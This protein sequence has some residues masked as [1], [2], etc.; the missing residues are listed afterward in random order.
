M[1][2]ASPFMYCGKGLPGAKGTSSKATE[3]LPSRSILPVCCRNFSRSRDKRLNCSLCTRHFS[4]SSRTLDCTAEAGQ[5]SK[6]GIQWRRYAPGHMWLL[7]AHAVCLCM[8]GAAS[9]S[10]EQQC[11]VAQPH[12]QPGCWPPWRTTGAKKSCHRSAPSQAWIVPGSACSLG[13][14]W[15]A[16]LLDIWSVRLKQL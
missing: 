10:T 14:L 1:E 2:V 12:R 15:L 3:L 13:T 6:R 8:A 9:T 11:L 16:R 5:W 4:S 7:R